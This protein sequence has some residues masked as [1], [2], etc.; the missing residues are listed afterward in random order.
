MN[1]DAIRRELI[2][3][4]MERDDRLSSRALS[5]LVDGDVTTPAVRSALLNL[6]RDGIVRKVDDRGGTRWEV[7]RSAVK[8]RLLS[9]LGA[10]GA[11]IDE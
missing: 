7:D 10:E 8:E 2:L 4:L 1:R 11:P 6:E 5:R 9:S 3:V